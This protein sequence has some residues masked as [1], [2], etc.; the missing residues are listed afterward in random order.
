MLH[1]ADMSDFYT[2]NPDSHT[3][4]VYFMHLR[5]RLS[6]NPDVPVLVQ[7]ATRFCDCKCIGLGGKSAAMWWVQG[8]H[9]L[10]PSRTR[11]H[12]HIG[13]L[14]AL[15]HPAG[16]AGWSCPRNWQRSAVSVCRRSEWDGP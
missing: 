8:M 1:S 13:L 10:R 7:T 6:R 9:S 11:R 3:V 16:S 15:Q 5:L 14:L 2:S 12:W 4:V